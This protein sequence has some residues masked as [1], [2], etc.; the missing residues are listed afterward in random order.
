MRE[1]YGLGIIPQKT[2]NFSLLFK[3]KPPKG[4]HTMFLLQLC[5]NPQVGAS[6]FVFVN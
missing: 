4:I 5:L 1:F 3:N 2:V 6:D